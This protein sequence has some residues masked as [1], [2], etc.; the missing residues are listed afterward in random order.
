MAS[1]IGIYINSSKREKIVKTINQMPER[2]KKFVYIAVPHDQ[3]RRYKYYM[4]YW[5]IL[6]IPKT[7]PRFLS[8][9]RQWVTENAKERFVFLMDDDLDFLV[10]DEAYKLKKCEPSDMDAMLA[11]VL[12]GLQDDQIPLI[13]ISTRLGNNRV[14]DDYTD[15]TRVTRCYALDKRVFDKVGARFD[16]HPD[17]SCGMQD[18]HLTL[19]WLNAGYPNRVYYNYAQVDSGSNASGGCSEYRDSEVMKRTV[20][21]MVANHPEVRSV[22]KTTKGGWDGMEKNEAGENVRTDVIVQWKKAYHPNNRSDGIAGFL[23]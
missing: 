10:R 1:K 16:P 4:K 22:V 15:I 20:K 14:T 11:Q 2:W 19:C 5:N 8:P 17:P 12:Y 21:W 6:S 13:G 23:K 3:V 7:V 9:Q 18:F